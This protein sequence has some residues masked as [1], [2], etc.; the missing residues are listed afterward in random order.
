MKFQKFHI[1]FQKCANFQIGIAL[2]NIF[3]DAYFKLKIVFGITFGQTD[4]FCID[5][6]ILNLIFKNIV[7]I[8]E[9]SRVGRARQIAQHLSRMNLGAYRY[10]LYESIVFGRPVPATSSKMIAYY[11]QSLPA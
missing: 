5:I 7:K 1:F 8:Y 9:W 2:N 11:S 4:I 6:A 3:V 10:G